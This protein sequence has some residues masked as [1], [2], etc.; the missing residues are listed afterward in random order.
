MLADAGQA[1]VTMA[2]AAAPSTSGLKAHSSNHLKT[3]IRLPLP[4][5][6]KRYR[7]C[8]NI[9]SWLRCCIHDCP[10]NCAPLPCFLCIEDFAP[11]PSS[12]ASP[13]ETRRF[14]RIGISLYIDFILNILS[15]LVDGRLFVES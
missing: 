4:C 1:D 15:T 12:A 10:E 6:L 7:S 3:V 5:P 11:C 8:W 13:L 9:D 2:P 14:L